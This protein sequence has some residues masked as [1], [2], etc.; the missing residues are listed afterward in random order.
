MSGDKSLT[1]L[2]S[3]LAGNGG[4]AVGNKVL[5]KPKVATPI[6]SR[7]GESGPKVNEKRATTGGVASPLVE[8]DFNSREWH[9]E[10]TITSTDGIFTLKVKR[11][12]KINF[13]DA[14]GAPVEIEFKAPG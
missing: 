4:G 12:K 3:M 7:T 13:T 11:A 9:P 8:T 10:S 5:P 6:P 1:E 2:V 14:S